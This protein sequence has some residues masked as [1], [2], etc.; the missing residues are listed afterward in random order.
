MTAPQAAAAAGLAAQACAQPT[1]NLGCS[2]RPLQAA[3][4]LT[5]HVCWERYGG[6]ARGLLLCHML[7]RCWCSWC[8]LGTWSLPW[9]GCPSDCVELSHAGV[10][11]CDDCFFVSCPQLC[12]EI[13]LLGPTA[14]VQHDVQLAAEI[15]RSAMP[16][17]GSASVFVLCITRGGSLCPIGKEC[18]QLELWKAGLSLQRAI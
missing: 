8:S 1:P 15:Q 16:W 17:F 4:W 13:C 5:W 6:S 11:S 2:G 18:G 12:C 14:R 9:W 10:V 7:R 3:C